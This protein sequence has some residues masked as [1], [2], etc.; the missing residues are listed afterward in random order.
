ML[1][2]IQFPNFRAKLRKNFDIEPTFYTYFVFLMHL[3]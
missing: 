1:L 2:S 3:P